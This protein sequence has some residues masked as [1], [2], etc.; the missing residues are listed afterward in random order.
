MQRKKGGGKKKAGQQGQGKKPQ[1][2]KQTN[3]GKG[4]ARQQKGFEIIEEPFGIA[5]DLP[6]VKGKGKALRRGG[7]KKGEDTPEG[8]LDFVEIFPVEVS[9]YIFSYLAKDKK[10]LLSLS[11]VSNAW[12]SIGNTNLFAI[13]SLIIIVKTAL[14]NIFWSFGESKQRGGSRYPQNRL[15]PLFHFASS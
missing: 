5:D 15:P 6:D 2:Q 13:S 10:T 4:G 3:G 1:Q 11:R 9:F 8:G 12:S 14:D 7:V